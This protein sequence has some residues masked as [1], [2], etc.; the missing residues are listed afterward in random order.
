MRAS[1]AIR[2]S[3]HSGA[4]IAFL[5]GIHGSDHHMVAFAHSDAPSFRR[6]SSDVGSVDEDGHGRDAHAGPW[7]RPGLRLVATC[8]ARLLPL[9]P[10]PWEAS[11]NIPP[12]IDYVPVDC[13]WKSGDHPPEDSFYVWG[14][15]P[16][17]D[18]THNYEA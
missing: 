4:G 6:L 18:F 1:S 9:R 16:P 13:D 15:N 2:L 14:P 5:H 12:D 17:E 8:S 3:D 7:L 10:R 11:P